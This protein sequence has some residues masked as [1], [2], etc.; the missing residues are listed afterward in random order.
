MTFNQ[1]DIHIKSRRI[2]T[3]QHVVPP[4]WAESLDAHGGDPSGWK[5]PKWSAEAAV[6]FMDSVGIAKGILSLTAPSVT[7]WQGEERREMARKVNDY[8]AELVKHE[9]ERFG[10]F[11]TVPLPDVEGAVLEAKRALDELGADGIILLSSYEGKYL[12]D[13]VFEPLWIELHERSSIVFVH[14]GAPNIPVIPGIP[15]PM[16]DYPFDTTRS[17]VDMV[18]NGVL[19]RYD[20]TKI[21]L[22]HAGG[23]V[24]YAAGRFAVVFRYLYPDKFSVESMTEQLKRFY[25]DTALSSTDVAMGALTSFAEPEHIFFG[26]DFPYASPAVAS[27]FTAQLDANTELDEEQHV[28][29]NHGNAQ[30]LLQKNAS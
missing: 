13:K 21:I 19:E 7:G 26:S 24:P 23:F 18:L 8:T 5:T 12:G 27:S 15:G 3:H 4:F 11:A 6:A 2:D 28:A 29:I 25:Y 10:H 17:A 14:P 20:K 16:V 30:K 1:S 22:S 9:P